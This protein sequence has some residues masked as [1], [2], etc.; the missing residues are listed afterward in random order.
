ML[1][2]NRTGKLA[3]LGVTAL[4]LGLGAVAP[5]FAWH[6]QYLT[7]QTGYIDSAG[8]FHASTSFPAGSNIADQ[9]TVTG[10]DASH[11]G[12][13]AEGLTGTVTFRLYSGSSCGG[14]A[15]STDT[16]SVPNTN[17]STVTSDPFTESTSGS[18]SFKAS[19]T[20]SGDWAGVTYTGSCEPF[21]LTPFPPP[22]VPE[23]PFG[24]VLLL[25]IA[26]PGLLFVRSKYAGKLSPTSPK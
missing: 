25:A 8:A 14:T 17:P 18:Y 13:T 10:C 19:F 22:G 2:N 4:V 26:I 20:G 7:T 16:K 24:M 15:I 3:L 12:S 21:T 1:E 9:A 5:A 11:C 6:I 23:F